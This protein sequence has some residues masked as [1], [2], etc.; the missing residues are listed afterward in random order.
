MSSGVIPR[1]LAAFTSAAAPISR[2]AAT[3]SSWCAAQCRAVAPSGCRAFASAPPAS[4]ARSSAASPLR[5]AAIRGCPPG[6]GVV[7]ARAASDPAQSAASS[8][9]ATARHRCRRRIPHQRPSARAAIP[10]GMDQSMGICPRSRW[11]EAPRRSTE[12]VSRA[13]GFAPRTA[14]ASPALASQFPVP[15]RPHRRA[16]PGP[17]TLE[18]AGPLGGTGAAYGFTTD[19]YRSSR[20]VL[21]CSRSTRIP[22]FSSTATCRFA[23]GVPP[24]TDRPPPAPRA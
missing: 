2:S 12:D 10:V 20:P 7:W 9:I 4:R 15:D 23:R 13:D 19:T 21:S 1:S 16:P 11:Q 17:G 3:A 14:L 5:T 22:S 6:A 8:G 24:S 18:P